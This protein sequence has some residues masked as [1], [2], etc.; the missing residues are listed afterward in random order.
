MDRF[1][2]SPTES[3]FVQ[4]PYPFYAAM[5]ESGHL[6]YWAELDIACAVSHVS[7]SRLLRHK[8]LGRERPAGVFA[9]EPPEHLA[10]FNMLEANSLLELEPPRHT[11]L[12]RLVTRAFNISRV[13]T[14]SKDISKTADQLIDAFPDGTFDLVAHFTK[15]LPVYV[16]AKLLGVPQDMAPQLL[17]W[18]NDIV[19]LY[20]SR[21]S[22]DLEVKAE[23]ASVEFVDY[24]QKH[25]QAHRRRPGYDLLTELIAASEDGDALS[26]DELISTVVLLLNAGHE[27]TV[28]ALGISVRT[29]LENE[30]SH[31]RLNP[32]HIVRTVDEILRYDAPLHMFKRYVY[33]PVDLF[34]QR[35]LPGDEVAAILAS[36][37]RDATVWENPDRFDPERAV[38]TSSSFGGGIHFCVGAPLARLELQIALPILFSRKPNLRLAETPQFANTWHFRGFDKL[39]VEA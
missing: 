8:S 21:R 18:S 25:I 34:G 22:Y 28:N 15:L 1:N 29:L 19:A 11:R 30:T 6:A 33:E 16:I 27:A 23:T 38:K 4:D 14:Y 39:M 12:R 13:S 32:V 9:P 24:L 7:V 35:F 10:T 26:D 5:R 36:G 20:Q 31:E 3:R 37:N 17:R 2:Q